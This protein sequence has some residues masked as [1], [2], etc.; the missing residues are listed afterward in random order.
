[1]S[2]HRTAQSVDPRLTRPLPRYVAVPALALCA[3][4]F[5]ALF[6]GWHGSWT[7]VGAALIAPG[8]VGLGALAVWVLERTRGRPLPRWIVV[9]CFVLFG[10][11]AGGFAAVL[12]PSLG[13]VGAGIL[14]GFFWGAIVGLGWARPR[15]AA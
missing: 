6:R 1:M 8:L 4:A 9:P 15:S 7:A 3:A 14:G 13:A 11:A 2:E 10:G 12:A 5:L